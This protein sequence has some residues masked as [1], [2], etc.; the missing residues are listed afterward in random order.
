MNRIFPSFLFALTVSLAARATW[1]CDVLPSVYAFSPSSSRV[2]FNSKMLFYL[3][4]SGAVP[5]PDIM[6]FARSPGARGFRALPFS[7]THVVSRNNG[8][9]LEVDL[10]GLT[11]G[12]HS[13]QISASPKWPDQFVLWEGTVTVE[14]ARPLEQPKPPLSFGFSLRPKP[15]L[16]ECL[17]CEYWRCAGDGFRLEGVGEA[18]PDS[19]VQWFLLYSSDDVLLSVVQ[20]DQGGRGFAFDAVVL[21][22]EVAGCL[23]VVAVTA[24][25]ERSAPLHVCP[26]LPQEPE[27]GPSAA[28]ID[29]ASGDSSQVVLA[30]ESLGCTC[31]QAPP[32]LAWWLTIFGLLWGVR[33]R[34]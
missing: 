34:G 33:R 1:A 9:W 14:G 30:E 31:S 3:D 6:V 4:A 2:P 18:A 19:N 26:P 11:S 5:R 29:G 24:R 7:R 27:G 22:K 16:Y 10:A 17:I 20:P 32:K 8:D 23:K 25:G 28:P 15:G 21:E 12:A 13:I